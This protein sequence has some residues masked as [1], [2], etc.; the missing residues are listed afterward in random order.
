MK[1]FAASI[2]Y[3]GTNYSGWQKQRQTLDTV[4]E[5]VE[6]ALS[7]IANEEIKVICSGRTD[8]GVHAISQVI[9]FDTN[10]K[11]FKKSWV[12]GT[13]SL[14]P[15]DIS[16]NWIKSVDNTFNARFSA[17]NRTYKYIVFNKTSCS[18]IHSNRVTLV[19]EKL[20]IDTMVKASRFLLGEKDFSSFRAS[21]C[22]SKT[23]MR[24][25]KEIKITKKKN[26]ITFEI[27]ANAFLF[28]M[29]RI[30]MGTLIN[31]GINKLDPKL[32]KEIL[33]AKDRK[34]ASKTFDSSGLYFIGPEYPMDF[35]LP[36]PPTRRQ[37]VPY[38]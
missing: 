13:N 24:N 4:Q 3:Y 38:I 18:I 10:A 29:V 2:E 8:A 1:R 26:T 32:M 9:H 35:K 15:N 16:I 12:E 25:V 14:L 28:N 19:K 22:Q 7:S 23:P 36:N 30:I 5:K 37:V 31:F 27:S 6:N 21:G 11:R 20:D 34:E 33:D 17:V